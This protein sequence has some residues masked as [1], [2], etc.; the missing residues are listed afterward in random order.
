MKG[1]SSNTT[2][3]S[4]HQTELYESLLASE[5]FKRE[6]YVVFQNSFGYPLSGCMR[7]GF[8]HVFVIERQ[9]LGWICHDPSMS[10]FMSVI[11]PATYEVDLIGT[12]A[13]LNPDSTIIQ[14]FVSQ[15]PKAKYFRWGW[16][17]GS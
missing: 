3:L 12:Y 17:T 15:S 8:E 13:E 2:R 1:R 11:L 14:L 10:D 7:D 16:L 6:L 4:D 9:A 5:E